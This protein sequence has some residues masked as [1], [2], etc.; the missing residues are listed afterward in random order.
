MKKCL[1]SQKV[2]RR[3]Y[4]MLTTYGDRRPISPSPLNAIPHLRLGLNLGR[5]PGWIVLI[6][7][8]GTCSS[9]NRSILH[10]HFI[11]RNVITSIMYTGYSSR[12]QALF[13]RINFPSYC[14]N[15]LRNSLFSNT[16]RCCSTLRVLSALYSISTSCK[17]SSFCRLMYIF[18]SVFMFNKYLSLFIFIEYLCLEVIIKKINVGTYTLK[19]CLDINNK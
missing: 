10:A 9:L 19:R 3:Y 11:V 1:A 18:H 13:N 14:P 15:I 6:F 4:Q 16:L 5:S 8:L 2:R 17:S 7:I 12:Y